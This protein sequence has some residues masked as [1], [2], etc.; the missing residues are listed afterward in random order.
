[1]SFEP[2]T[3]HSGSLEH[4]DRRN[5]VPPRVRLRFPHRRMTSVKLKFYYNVESGTTI[6]RLSRAPQY[7]T[8]D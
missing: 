6:T 4:D 1:M 8:T 7:S 3:L 5:K 2:I